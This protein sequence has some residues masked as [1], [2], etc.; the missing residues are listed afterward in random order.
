MLY[1]AAARVAPDR[2]EKA[3]ESR[4]G[5]LAALG[6]AACWTITAMS[7]ESAGRRVGSLSV[8]LI[9]LVF[10]LALLT[11]WSAIFRGRVFPFDFPLESWRW[12]VLSGIVGFAVGDLLLFRAFVVVGSRISM[13]I[14]SSVPPI[15]ALVGL[16]ALGEIL[17][18][19]QVF[20]MVLTVAGIALVVLERPARN[21]PPGVATGSPVVAG[22][23]A[24]PTGAALPAERPRGR[25]TSGVLLAFG[26]AA[27]QAVGLVLAKKGM[28]DLDPFAATQIRVLAGTVGFVAIFTA[29]RRWARFSAAWR[30]GSAMKRIFTGAFFGPFL[31][32]SLSLLAVQRT[33]TGAASTIMAIVPVLIIPPAVIL[34][35]ERV[36]VREV[37]GAV[38]AVAGVSVMFF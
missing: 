35:R 10:G 21:G 4:L 26:G 12:L 20:G 11:V 6:T 22:S 28:G 32:V 5:E 24:D 36:T 9:R 25:A 17:S 1:C 14:M 37:L 7:F 8:N 3:M 18:A 33:S 23:P 13:L 31:G 38:I 2:E 29:T 15:T 30:H 19:M 16:A 27:G 34:F